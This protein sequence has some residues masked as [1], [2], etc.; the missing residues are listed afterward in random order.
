MRFDRIIQY[1]N[2]LIMVQ[3]IMNAT[4]SIR[5]H[6]ILFKRFDQFN[7]VE[8]SN[9]GSEYYKKNG[10]IFFKV[11]FY[12]SKSYW[13]YKYINNN[14]A[15]SFKRHI[16]K[17][18]IIKK[19]GEGKCA[20]CY[21]SRTTEGMPV[22]LKCTKKWW[23]FIDRKHLVETK[24]LSKIDHP[25]I[26]KI[27][28]IFNYENIEGFV[29]E[30]KPGNTIYKMVVDEKKCFSYNETVCLFKKVL[31][32]VKYLHDNNIVHYDLKPDNIIVY[33]DNISLIDFGF[34]DY[35]R[36]N[37]NDYVYD[38]LHLGNL[39]LFLLY[40]NYNG[41]TKGTWI[42]QLG[43]NKKQVIFIKKLLLILEPQ[44]SITE[45]QLEFNSLFTIR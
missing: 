35:S 22:V 23:F 33:N 34:S 2:R 32:V 9:I 1:F 3:V 21:Y 10:N 30:Y 19:L 15:L 4:L 31:L 41:Y 27:V 20:I 24:I 16:G 45:I 6:M 29:M 25:S 18:Q 11:I 26:P 36:K 43:L 44:S 28:D 12:I 5:R 7:C 40:S 14:F 37:R 17:Y 38:Y 39:I 42:E 8:K 13:K